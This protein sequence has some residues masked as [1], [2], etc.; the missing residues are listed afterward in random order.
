MRI[1]DVSRLSGAGAKATRLYEARGLLPPI[2]PINR[3]RHDSEQDLAWIR[4]IRLAL[5]LGI[6][7][8]TIARLKQ[9]DGQLDWP[10]V[11]ALLQRRQQQL[12]L[13]CGRLARLQ[14]RL[15]QLDQGLRL[16]L[17]HGGQCGDD[18]DPYS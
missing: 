1:S 15:Q 16:W 4:M 14:A 10:A 12:A 3:Y 5:S 6:P 17:Q 13:E 8:A 7:L 2:T 11:L 9:A 18:D